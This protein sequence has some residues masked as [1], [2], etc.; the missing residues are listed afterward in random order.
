MT[1]SVHSDAPTSIPPE[2]SDTSSLSAYVHTLM[3]ENTQATPSAQE[4]ELPSFLN[5]TD[6]I[7]DS[8]ADKSQLLNSDP[9]KITFTTPAEDAENGKQPDYYLSTEGK[10]VKNPQATPS[11]DGSIKIEVEGNNSEKEAK[12]YADKLQKQAIASL[13][14]AFKLANPGAKVPEMWQ[15]ILDAQPELSYPSIIDNQNSQ[16][17]DQTPNT[18]QAPSSEGMQSQPYSSGSTS[19][20]A[21]DVAYNSG[22]DSPASGPNTGFGGARAQGT[23]STSSI[24]TGALE[25]ASV[26]GR[27]IVENAEADVNKALWN[28]KPEMCSVTNN[29][30]LGCAESVS[31]VLKES[32]ITG[33]DSPSV[34]VM[35]QQLFAIGAQEVP[36]NS[37]QPGDVVVFGSDDHT[38]IMGA[39]GAF[40][41]NDSS[42]GKW[43]R[44]NSVS[45]LGQT[46]TSV[47]RVPGSQATT[48]T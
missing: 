35:R 6:D 21:A 10:L 5:F 39:D 24:N 48:R 4:Q 34:A 32:G 31:H 18:T 2:T 47:I 37:A 28:D 38:G 30:D 1:Y 16:Q 22:G 8:P 27:S 7:Y 26:T 33:V 42:T 19:G 41:A 43:T 40:Y 12:Q 45:D 36:L 3:P 20:S 14:N 15:E 29:G 11:A 9:N 23:G 25:T 46:V 17:T 13:V 44:Y